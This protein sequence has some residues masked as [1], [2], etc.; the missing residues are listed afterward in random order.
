MNKCLL[1]LETLEPTNRLPSPTFRVQI[2]TAGLHS[3]KMMKGCEVYQS[4]VEYL[5]NGLY[6]YA[7]GNCAQSTEKPTSLNCKCKSKDSPM[8][9]SL[10]LK[11]R[12]LNL[13]E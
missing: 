7:V 3:R 12:H 9:L 10:N 5:R 6:K 11:E 13:K 8:R 4:P 2:M 1:P